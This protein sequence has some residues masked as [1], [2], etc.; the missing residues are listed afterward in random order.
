LQLFGYQQSLLIEL[1]DID[2]PALA[3][4]LILVEASA[5]APASV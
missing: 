1:L 4:A 3:D 2:D 5:I